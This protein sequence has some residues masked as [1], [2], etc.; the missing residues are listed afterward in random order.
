MK[1]FP[2]D[3]TLIIEIHPGGLHKCAPSSLYQLGLVLDLLI[4]FILFIFIV[5]TRLPETSSYLRIR[6][7]PFSV[8]V[9]I[10]FNTLFSHICTLILFSLLLSIQ[11]QTSVAAAL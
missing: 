4:Y 6:N 7:L 10:H 2:S 5:A 9:Y 1:L 3:N 8:A 11:L